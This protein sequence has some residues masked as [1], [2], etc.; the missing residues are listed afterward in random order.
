[1]IEKQFTMIENVKEFHIYSEIVPF[2]TRVLEKS[3]LSWLKLMKYYSFVLHTYFC[4]KKVFNLKVLHKLVKL[5][6]H[7]AYWSTTHD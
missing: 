1:M 7:P 4:D 5:R 2:L 3:L 6:N